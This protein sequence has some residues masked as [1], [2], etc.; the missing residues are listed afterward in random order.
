MSFYIHVFLLCCVFMLQLCSTGIPDGSEEELSV[1]RA[2]N[3]EWTTVLDTLEDGTQTLINSEEVSTMMATT[4]LI[5]QKC[6]T[7]SKLQFCC[8]ST[9]ACLC[10]IYNC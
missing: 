1:A 2:L 10:E 6:P 5:K 8:N 3:L 9:M 4:S 7:I